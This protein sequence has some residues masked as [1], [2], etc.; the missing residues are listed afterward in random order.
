M[1]VSRAYNIRVCVCVVGGGGVENGMDG[2]KIALAIVRRGLR[3]D[4]Y[5][6]VDRVSHCSGMRTTEMLVIL[7]CS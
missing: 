4:S 5:L 1:H 2:R 7:H 3:S 6:F